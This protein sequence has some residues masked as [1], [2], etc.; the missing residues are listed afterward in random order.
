VQELPPRRVGVP[1]RSRRYPPPLQDAAEGGRSHAVA[2]LEQLTL[3]LW[4]PQL[5]FSLAMRVISS[6]TAAETGGR[7]R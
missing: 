4:Y 6:V 1:D 7:P 3:D 5:G 2:E